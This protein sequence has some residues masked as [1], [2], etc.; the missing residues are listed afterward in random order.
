MMIQAA[1]TR[2]RSTWEVR[3]RIRVPGLRDEAGRVAAEEVLAGID[4]VVQVTV[5]AQK[6][7]VVVDYLLTKT[8]YPSLE[9]ALDAA[10][11]APVAGRWARFKSGWYQNLDL[12]GRDNASAP[13]P[14][15]CSR[16][17]SVPS[18]P[19]RH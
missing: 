1:K 9:R 8:D 13:A 7:V 11:L 14:A 19:H 18:G 2:T 12:T 17:P 3:R 15:C 4:G 10:G 16:P 5:K 6:P